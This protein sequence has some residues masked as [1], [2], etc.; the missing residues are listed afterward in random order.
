MW[1]LDSGSEALLYSKYSHTLCHLPAK[2]LTPLGLQH[3][4]TI[5]GALA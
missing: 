1:V 4:L 2:P 3:P 5:L